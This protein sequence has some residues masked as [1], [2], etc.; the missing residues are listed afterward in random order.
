MAAQKNKRPA[1][2]LDKLFK[3]S[4]RAMSYRKFQEAEAAIVPQMPHPWSWPDP[5]S[6]TQWT[7]MGRKAHL[8]WSASPEHYVKNHSLAEHS[9]R[10]AIEHDQVWHESE[11]GKPDILMMWLATCRYGIA[12]GRTQTLLQRAL[13]N[14]ETGKGV[15]GDGGYLDRMLAILEKEVTGETDQARLDMIYKN[16]VAPW[17]LGTVLRQMGSSQADWRPISAS[18]LPLQWPEETVVRLIRLR[19]LTQRTKTRDFS[20]DASKS[21][22]EQIGASPSPSVIKALTED[23]ID[24]VEN[25][26]DR[27]PLGA[28]YAI[29]H[30]VK[31]NLEPDI[32][33]IA[34]L[35]PHAEC[36]TRMPHLSARAQQ[37]M[38]DHATPTIHARPGARVR[39]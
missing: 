3:A 23:V 6:D 24:Q 4:M 34:A 11:P 27:F 2:P 35:S 38:L 19:T 39:L 20:L 13:K 16:T 37:Y 18:S 21:L 12:H 25:E 26:N 28:L 1:H 15:P 10:L 5:K 8:L 30:C 14:A 33:L 7:L 29:D 31:A 36:L 22:I 17:L 9:I 32:R